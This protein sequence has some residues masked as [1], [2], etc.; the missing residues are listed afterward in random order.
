MKF[1]VGEEKSCKVYDTSVLSYI[2]KNS[3]ATCTVHITLFKKF[4]A[5][6]GLYSLIYFHS[7][8]VS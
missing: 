4:A 7:T 3:S 2:S 6:Y 1:Y 8:V 5:F